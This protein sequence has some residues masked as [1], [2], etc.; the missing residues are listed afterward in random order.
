MY[1]EMGLKLDDGNRYDHV[2]KLVETSREGE[3]QVQTDRTSSDNRSYIIIGEN[4][5]KSAGRCRCCNCGRPKC[6]Q[7]IS[8]EDSKI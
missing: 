6:H 5:Q 7:E 3:V 4:G 8:R 2:H 1:N